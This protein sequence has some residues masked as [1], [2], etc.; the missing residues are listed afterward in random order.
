MSQ[1]VLTYLTDTVAEMLGMPA[2]EIDA[3]TLLTAYGLNSVDFIDIVVQLETRY[4]VQ[5]DPA[6]LKDLS[7]ATLAAL[8][9][10][11][12]AVC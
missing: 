5:F 9:A 7:V 12:S 11:Q 2:A 3:A 4:S 10:E 6:A 8:V 1:A